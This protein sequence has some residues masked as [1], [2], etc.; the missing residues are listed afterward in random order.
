ME[1]LR[2]FSRNLLGWDS[3]LYRAA[4]Q[5]L[6][7]SVLVRTEGIGSAI[8]IWRLKNVD[9][10]S[11]QPVELSFRKLKYPFL[12]RPGTKDVDTAINNF[13]REE[14]GYAQPMGRP[15]TL[16]DAGAYIGDTSAYFLSKYS[17]LQSWALEP[18]PESRALAEQN[19]APY[20]ARAKILPLAL[21]ATG[22]PVRFSGEQTGARVSNSEGIE[23]Q[24]TTIGML[25][26]QIP[27]GRIDI[28]KLDIEGAEGEIFS[29]SPDKWLDRIGFIVVE[30]HGP[31][32]TKTV[33][34]TL[35]LNG[36]S[37]KHYRNLYYC[38][39]GGRI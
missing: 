3:R 24:S 11:H 14:Y 28:L 26:E 37:V 21:T 35:A 7:I 12:I 20:G 36:W 19:L 22:T 1:K 31:A 8:K 33:L 27:E 32:I 30:T 6:E 39:P 34:D 29:L 4:S 13:S 10:Q 9:I 15:T 2:R 18:N 38:W 25:L 23:V 17:E 5:A 16:V